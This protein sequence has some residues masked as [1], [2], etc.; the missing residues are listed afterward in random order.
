MHNKKNE[1]RIPQH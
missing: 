1:E